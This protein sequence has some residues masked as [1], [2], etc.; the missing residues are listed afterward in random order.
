MAL[1]DSINNNIIMI[2]Q[3][4]ESAVDKVSRSQVCILQI[5]QIP[6]GHIYIY[7]DSIFF[8]WLTEYIQ[9]V[10]SR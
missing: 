4:I 1:L 7:I 10:R 9:I 3:D 6:K 2:F 8:A 5:L